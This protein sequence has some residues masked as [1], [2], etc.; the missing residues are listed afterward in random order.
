M[1][2]ISSL[3]TLAVVGYAQT[4][5]F[6]SKDVFGNILDQQIV[7]GVAG[8]SFKA[9]IDLGVA[10]KALDQLE[11]E[12]SKYGVG[13]CKFYMG[14]SGKG[15]KHA[16]YIGTLEDVCNWPN[17]STDGGNFTGYLNVRNLNQFKHHATLT[18]KCP[19]LDVT[20]SKVPVDGC[21]IDKLNTVANNQ[22]KEK[23]F[24]FNHYFRSPRAYVKEASF[25]YLTQFGKIFLGGA[26]PALDLWLDM[27]NW[28]VFKKQFKANFAS[29]GLVAPHMLKGGKGHRQESYSNQG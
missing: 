3:S 26:N 16:D 13:A 11:L 21:E 25:I 28:I 4:A 22:L 9:T 17:V 27:H 15:G 19:I 12:V 29:A 10:P 8:E 5:T 7:E 18:V 1:N 14:K 23:V 20:M 6:T 2:L 24:D